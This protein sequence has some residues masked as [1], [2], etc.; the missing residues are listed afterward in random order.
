MLQTQH[1]LFKLMSWRG[2]ERELVDDLLPFEGPPQLFCLPTKYP[3][4]RFLCRLIFG[5]T[6]SG[7]C[8]NQQESFILG[9]AQSDLSTVPGM[10]VVPFG[11]NNYEHFLTNWKWINSHHKGSWLA[12]EQDWYLVS[13]YMIYLGLR[14]WVQGTRCCP[15]TYK[16]GPH[17][18]EYEATRTTYSTRKLVHTGTRENIK[19]YINDSCETAMI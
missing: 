18:Y 19:K 14:L 11:I 7:F 2:F 6:P 12:D 4:P 1:I 17:Y 5:N 10:I 13:Y 15:R 16:R 3:Y 9:T 8:Q